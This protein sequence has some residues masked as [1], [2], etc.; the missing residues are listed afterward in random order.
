LGI[1]VV[2]F[3]AFIINTIRCYLTNPKPDEEED[4]FDNFDNQHYSNPNERNNQRNNNN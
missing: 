4:D 3:L 2:A 1:I